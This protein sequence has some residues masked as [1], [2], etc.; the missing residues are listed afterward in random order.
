[1]GTNI[2]TGEE[3]AKGILFSKDLE[4]KWVSLDWLKKEIRERQKEGSGAEYIL[5]TYYSAL[6]WVLSLFEG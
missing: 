3:I 5:E 2:K 4:K 6:D 1:M